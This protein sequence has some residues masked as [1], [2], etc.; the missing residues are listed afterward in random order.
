MKKLFSLIKAVCSQDMDLFKFKNNGNKF[1]KIFLFTFLC[2]IL[3]ISFG[4][5]YYML[6]ENL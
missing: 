1:S 6:A 4:T 2:I 5:Y 3:M